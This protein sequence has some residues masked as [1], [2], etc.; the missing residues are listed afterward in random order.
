MSTQTQAFSPVDSAR[1]TAATFGFWVCLLTAAITIISFSIAILTPPRSGPFCIGF[2]VLYPYTDTASFYPRDFWWM[3]PALS[4]TPL[5]LILCAC[6]HSWVAASRTLFSRIAM[7][8]A[9][10]ATSLIMLDYVLQIEVLQPSLLR[11]ETDGMAFISQ[12]NPHGLFIAIENLGYLL[13]SISMCFL[14]LALPHNSRLD[15]FVRW[16]MIVSGAA[17]LVTFIA[18]SVYFGVRL[19]TR[20]E[21]AIITIDWFALIIGSIV[22]SMVFRRSVRALRN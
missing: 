20:F 14:G 17:G 15:R 2:C 16:E 19:E 18:M 21:L 1:V 13:M 7:L 8:F 12:Y 6:T 3:F 11:A 5:F 10:I 22:L 4:I 9:A